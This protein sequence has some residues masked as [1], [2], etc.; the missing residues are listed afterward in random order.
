MPPPTF[1]FTDIEG[2]TGH[3]ERAPDAM[4]DALARHDRWLREAIAA[5]GGRVVKT[6]GDGVMAVFDA[7]RDA[8]RASVDAQR[9]LQAPGTGDDLAL[10]VRMGL[11]T[12]DAD[13]RDGDY[14]GA[15][16]TRAARIMAAAYGG[17]TIRKLVASVAER[18]DDAGLV[19][20]DRAERERQ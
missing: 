7:P 5:H 19:A 14:F 11:H 2:S 6:T 1:L 9:R 12:G 13:E 17:Q 10:N 15:A 18:P 3:W 4:K 8:L 20:V 16:P